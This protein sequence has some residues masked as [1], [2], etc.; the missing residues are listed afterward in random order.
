LPF[1]DVFFFK[2]VFFSIFFQFAAEGAVKVFFD[3]SMSHNGALLCRT[4]KK[5][6]AKLVDAVTS[7]YIIT[8]YALPMFK[9]E[10]QRSKHAQFERN[11]KDPVKSHRP[12]LP[13]TGPGAGGR[14]GQAGGT[15]SSYL[16]R[17]LGYATKKI[18]EDIDP[19]QALL[20]HAKEAAEN[21]YWVS[22]A[23]A[24]TQP[25]TIFQSPE[26]GEDSGE[27]ASKR[28]KH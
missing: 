2:I 6:R 14:V 3:P 24:K 4:S 13:M 10:K 7:D 5:R 19:R 28:A 25:K 15:L 9:E 22:P 27:S 26:P 17:K 16:V 12:E 20:R 11:R 18:D 8:P 21:P 1:W 23:Y